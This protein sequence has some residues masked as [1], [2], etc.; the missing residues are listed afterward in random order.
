M[1]SWKEIIGEP[2]LGETKEYVRLTVRP[3]AELAQIGGY[4]LELCHHS[5]IE[6]ALL[7]RKTTFSLFGRTWGDSLTV[8][9]EGRPL[10]SVEEVVYRMAMLYALA[11]EDWQK[12]VVYRT[13]REIIEHPYELPCYLGMVVDLGGERALATLEG[14]KKAGDG[15][16]FSEDAKK[17]ASDVYRRLVGLSYWEI[18]K[19]SLIQMMLWNITGWKKDLADFGKAPESMKGVVSSR[20]TEARM[21]LRELAKVLLGR[22]LVSKGEVVNIKKAGSFHYGDLIGFIN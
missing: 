21:H 8:G 10:L 3:E 7:L 6:A 1:S 14:R 13:E 12:A 11:D 4:A 5:E 16:G 18:D 15:R 22:G 2:K 19:D 9:D 17:M 20:L